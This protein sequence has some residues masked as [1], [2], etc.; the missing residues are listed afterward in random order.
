[1]HIKSYFFSD[2]IVG[3]EGSPVAG[4]GQDNHKEEIQEGSAK[5]IRAFSEGKNI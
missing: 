1:M 2:D 3:E 4:S 5:K